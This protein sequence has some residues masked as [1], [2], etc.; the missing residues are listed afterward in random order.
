MPPTPL[1]E[2]QVVDGPVTVRTTE[3]VF[4]EIMIREVGSI[5]PLGLTLTLTTRH[6]EVLEPGLGALDRYRT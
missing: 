1:F 4:A 6:T 5:S 2:E 3:F